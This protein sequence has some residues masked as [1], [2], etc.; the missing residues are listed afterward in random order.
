LF[1]VFNLP[2]SSVERV[3]VLAGA[4]FLFDN[5]RAHLFSY[6]SSFIGGLMP[7]GAPPEALLAFV[8]LLVVVLGL[9]VVVFVVLS[10]GA[11]P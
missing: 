8:L 7:V 1:I 3:K 4:R 6:F 9:V 10:A 5:E 2:F 11:A